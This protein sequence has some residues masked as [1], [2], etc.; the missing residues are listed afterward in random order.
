M[1]YG[2]RREATANIG[3]ELKA[4]GWKLFGWKEDMSDSMTDY[5]NPESWDGIAT[6]GDLVA[7]I[8]VSPYFQKYRSGKAIEKFFPK[9]DRTCDRCKGTGVEPDA[10]TYDEAKKNPSQQHANVNSKAKGCWLSLG[11]RVV[12]PLFYHDNG[13]PKCDRCHGTGNLMG[14]P[15]HEVVGHYPTFG[16]NPKGSTWHVEKNGVVVAKGIGLNKG[17]DNPDGFVDAMEKKLRKVR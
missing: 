12:S 13:D 10:L 11:D 8:D 17:V 3:K 4:R 16:A 15:H 6:K 7:L 2:E 9:V 5:Y 1:Y 14:E